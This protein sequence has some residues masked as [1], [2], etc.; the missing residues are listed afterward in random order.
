M[1]ELNGPLHQLNQ[2]NPRTDKLKITGFD[3]TTENAQALIQ[4]SAGAPKGALRPLSLPSSDNKCPPALTV[5][6]PFSLF[7]GYLRIYEPWR[8]ANSSSS[9]R[10]ARACIAHILRDLE[11]RRLARSLRNLGPVRIENNGENNHSAGDHLTDKISHPD[12]DQAVSEHADQTC[13]K[14]SAN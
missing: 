2:L 6:R 13:A 14:K 9:E 5:A 4:T 10:R 12:Q 7:S 3:F 1:T 8:T 11:R